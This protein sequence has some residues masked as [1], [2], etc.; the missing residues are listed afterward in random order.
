[1][2]DG[3]TLN[4]TSWGD[5]AEIEINQNAIARFNEIFPN[6]TVN[7]T[8]RPEQYQTSIQ[9]DFAA[10]IAPDV[11][12]VDGALYRQLAPNNQLLD[13][14]PTMDQLG[15]N[16]NEVYVEALL[17]LF[18]TDGKILGVPKDSGSLGLFINNRLAQEA[19]VD[20]ASITSWDQWRAAAQAMTKEG[21]FGQC[22]SS[23][24]NRI[25]AFMLQ[26]GV[27]PVQDGQV[28]LADPK[29][30][31]AL[32]FWYGLHRDKFAELPKN[33]GAD[34]CGVAFGQ[35]Q[36]AMAVEGGW[37]FPTMQKD[38]PDVDY[39]V[40]EL[41]QPTGGQPGNLLFTNAWGVS[42]NTQYPQAA[43]A[44][45]LFL[46]SPQNQQEILRTGFALPSV[47]ALLDDPYFEQNPNAAAIAAANEYG[48]PAATAFGGFTKQDDV[49]KAINTQ[50]ESLFLGTG[51]PQTTLQQASQDVQSVV[52]SQ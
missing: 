31:E 39:T 7:Y 25:G 29:A 44:L 40:V 52:S 21:T 13:L 14:K 18:I 27:T 41:P 23:D 50:M 1:V 15:V 12:Y 2:E 46:A 19:G 42:V 33:I 43:A 32:D 35:E 37:L 9:G 47:Q 48:T 17:N 5:A 4:V 24:I 38:Y 20:P 36:T 8:P 10:G 22:G 16:P 49:I 11:L 3:A 34:W 51:D 6:V 26:N 45:A 28:N 30:V